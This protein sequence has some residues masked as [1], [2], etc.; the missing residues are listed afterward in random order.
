MSPDMLAQAPWPWLLACFHRSPE[1]HTWEVFL[2]LWENEKDTFLT[3][4]QQKLFWHIRITT[5]VLSSFYNDLNSLFHNT[6]CLMLDCWSFSP[7]RESS[8]IES[9]LVEIKDLFYTKKFLQAVLLALLPGCSHSSL[10]SL[11]ACKHGGGSLGDLV[12]CYVVR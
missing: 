3:R 6:H 2:L 8:E 1:Y 10:W 12:M 11:A 4:L 5:F 7:V 9:V